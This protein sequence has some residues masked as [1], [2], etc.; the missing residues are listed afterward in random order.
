MGDTL[1]EV[2]NLRTYFR[3]RV[4][5]VKAVDGVSFSID[6]Q[7]T[8]GLVGESGCG[9]SILAQSI[10]QIQQWP[11]EVESGEILL[12]AA[13][14]TGTH[15]LAKP[16]PKSEELRRIRGRE[17][18]YIHQEPM[19]ALS[20]LH[21]VGN[22]L[23]E[24]LLVH[25]ADMRAAEAGRLCVEMLTEVGIPRAADRMD[26]YIFNFSGGMRQR[27]MIAMALLNHPRLLMAD[28]PTTSVDV[29]IQAQVLELMK[30]IQKRYAM[31]I[32]FITHNLGILAEVAE[33]I[34]VMYL[35]KIVEMASTLAIFAS[36][37]HPYTRA[38]IGSI[39]SAQ[40]KRGELSSIRGSVPDPYSRPGGCS[41][42]D[43]CEQMK[44]GLCDVHVPALVE[45]EPGCTVRC[46]LYSD[47][48]DP[49]DAVEVPGKAASIG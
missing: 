47:E 2:K 34:M 10:L 8:L 24:A 30:A 6:R 38:L 31:S 25:N 21:T 32:L 17:I 5:V 12:H 22:Q 15:D 28:E 45:V 9:K 35:G 19:A 40:H 46:F 7:R 49:E 13:D 43:R 42:H 44:A 39:P 1:L 3:T 18:S 41:F 16:S 33:E 14:G 11:G 36:P 26:S 20:L 27:V 23:E 48:I 4:G 37:K 29:T